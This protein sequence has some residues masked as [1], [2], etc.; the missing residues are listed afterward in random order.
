MDERCGGANIAFHRNGGISD[1]S[2]TKHEILVFPQ[3]NRN[4]THTTRIHYSR[5]YNLPAVGM[6]SMHTDT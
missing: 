5:N 4:T 3:R 1:D 6:G 2:H